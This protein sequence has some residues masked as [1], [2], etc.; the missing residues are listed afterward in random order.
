MLAESNAWSKAINAT[1]KWLLGLTM[2]RQDE[3]LVTAK[4]LQHVLTAIPEDLSAAGVLAVGLLGI[5]F[6]GDTL[7]QVPHTSQTAVLQRAI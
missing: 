3:V 7:G 1:N 4:V 2:S 6:A 5:L